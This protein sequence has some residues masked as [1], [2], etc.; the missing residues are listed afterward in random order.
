[1]LAQLLEIYHGYCN[2]NPFRTKK[3]LCAVMS[4][5]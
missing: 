2:R 3:S 5:V 4:Q 1:M